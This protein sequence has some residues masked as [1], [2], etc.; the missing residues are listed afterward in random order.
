MSS[1]EHLPYRLGVGITLFN[2]DGLVWVGRRIDTKNAWQMPQGG[3]EDD[4]S[5]AEAALR[6][7]EEEVGTANAELIGETQD[8]LTYDLPP[9]VLRRTWRGRFRGQKQKWFA[10]RFLGEESEIDLNAHHS[11]EFEE[12][13]WVPLETLPRLIVRFKRP[14]YE[15]VVQEFS[16]IARRLA[17]PRG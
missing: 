14:L 2:R 13:K 16:P 3:I 8:W 9:H 15:Q 12:W 6:E 5:P 17:T 1:I 4:D 7:L 10:A 11:P